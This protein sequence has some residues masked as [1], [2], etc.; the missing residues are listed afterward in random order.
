LRVWLKSLKKVQIKPNFFFIIKKYQKTDTAD[1]KTVKK[2]F[3]KCT[4][5]YE[6]KSLCKIGKNAH[7]RQVFAKNIFWYIF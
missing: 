2:V 4:K 1:F 7:F 3:K 6:Q 5:S